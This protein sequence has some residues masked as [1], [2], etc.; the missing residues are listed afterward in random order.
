MTAK[1]N[2]L[3]LELEPDKT[4]SVIFSRKYK[5]NIPA[6]L[7]INNLNLCAKPSVKFLGVYLDSKLNWKTHINYI[8]EKCEKKINILKTVY[9][10][11]WG[12][13]PA[14]C[15]LIYRSFIRRHLDYSCP[16]FHNDAKTTTNKLNVIQYGCIRQCTGALK[17]S[18][19]NAL[20]TEAKEM[21]KEKFYL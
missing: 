7:S 15:L 9:N 21:P 10:T 8:I 11:T 14:T 20:I 6:S 5:V 1:L 12:A 13:D 19:T 16:L 17:S 18:P 4:T 3:G 2:E